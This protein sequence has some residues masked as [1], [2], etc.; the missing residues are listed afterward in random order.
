[1]SVK[2]Q[3]LGRA[4]LF[5]IAVLGVMGATLLSR[6]V[7][8]QPRDG[9]SLMERVRELEERVRELEARVASLEGE[10]GRSTSPGSVK[11]FPAETASTEQGAARTD[12]DP[13]YVVDFRGTRLLK[14]GCEGRASG[15]RCDPLWVV[16]ARGVKSVRQ[17]CQQLLFG[18]CAEP[19][20]LDESG[21]R[22]LRPECL[23]V[24]Y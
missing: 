5:S 20:Q 23:D 18:T 4:A 13:A 21:R 3:G 17:G 22:I 6:D 16:D 11:A 15:N 2:S 24:G 10:K 14:A 1:M 9:R 12:C 8:S 7:L 19:Y